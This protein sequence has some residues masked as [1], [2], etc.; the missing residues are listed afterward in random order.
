MGQGFRRW[1]QRTAWGLHMKRQHLPL[2]ARAGEEGAQR[3]TA[4]G[5]QSVQYLSLAEVT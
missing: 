1:E 4:R 5:V 3:L 2:V